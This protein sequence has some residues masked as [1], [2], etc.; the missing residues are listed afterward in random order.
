[1]KLCRRR[2]SLVREEIG[3]QGSEIAGGGIRVSLA[4]RA[5][6]SH[7]KNLATPRLLGLSTSSYPLDSVVNGRSSGQRKGAIE[8]VKGIAQGLSI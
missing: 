3:R 4:S 1:M 6:E 5:I 8:D 2:E 7:N